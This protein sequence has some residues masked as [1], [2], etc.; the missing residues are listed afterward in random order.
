[1]SKFDDLKKQATDKGKDF[2]NE[3]V[4]KQQE[5]RLKG[6][7]GVNEHIDNAQEKFLGSDKK[8]DEK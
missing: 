6:K 8:E 7:D 3:Q 2:A 4:D 5:E 1:M